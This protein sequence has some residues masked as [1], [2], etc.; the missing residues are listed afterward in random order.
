LCSPIPYQHAHNLARARRRA[1][2]H[3]SN[4]CTAT[5]LSN[6]K[7]SAWGRTDGSGP[8]GGTRVGDLSWIR[9]Q[10]GECIDQASRNQCS[11]PANVVVLPCVEVLASC[12]EQGTFVLPGTRPSAGNASLPH[13]LPIFVYPDAYEL[14]ALPL[15]WHQFRPV[16]CGRGR[17]P[18][19]RGPVNH[20]AAIP[21]QYD[22]GSVICSLP[23]QPS[24]TKST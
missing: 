3:F 13:S 10:Q 6:R 1:C 7:R 17:C 24:V 19:L 15:D 22:T 14:C 9:G 23:T 8:T 5:P 11:H 2:F 16:K 12:L 18:Q 4:R 21:L 20:L